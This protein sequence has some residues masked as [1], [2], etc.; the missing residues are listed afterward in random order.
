MC[1]AFAVS[2]AY[3]AFLDTSFSKHP[4]TTA[5]YILIHDVVRKGIVNESEESTDSDSAN[6]FTDGTTTKK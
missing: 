6:G 4:A 1:F 5:F 2:S 3:G